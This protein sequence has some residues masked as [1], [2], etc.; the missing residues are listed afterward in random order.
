MIEL[1]PDQLIKLFTHLQQL[2][3]L[4]ENDA[5]HLQWEEKGGKVYSVHHGENTVFFLNTDRSYAGGNNLEFRI[6]VKKKG[7][8]VAVDEKEAQ[9]NAKYEELV[10]QKIKREVFFS[11]KLKNLAKTVNLLFKTIKLQVDISEIKQVA[12]INKQLGL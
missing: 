2:T 3:T 8:G 4:P 5:D 10:Y 12:E 9:V 7:K 1:S 6:L 11:H